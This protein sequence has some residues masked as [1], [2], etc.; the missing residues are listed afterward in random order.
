MRSRPRGSGRRSRRRRCGNTAAWGRDRCGRPRSAG[1]AGR[2][3][4][5]P[6]RPRCRS[7]SSAST[8]SS[9]RPSRR[10]ASA[11]GRWWLRSVL[12]MTRVSGPATASSRSATSSGAAAVT[13]GSTGN[14]GSSERCRNGT[15]TSSECSPACGPSAARTPGTDVARS[16]ARRIHRYGAQRR[17]PLR[18]ARHRGPGQRDEV[19]RPEQ[20]RPGRRPRPARGR[21]PSRPPVPSSGSRRAA[22]PAPATGR[23]PDGR[24]GRQQRVDVGGQPGRV[25]RVEPPGHRG[26]A[27]TR[28]ST[29]DGRHRRFSDTG[30]RRAPSCRTVH[31]R[32]RPPRRR[33]SRTGRRR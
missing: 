14:R 18:R 5:R 15:C 20:D 2:R 30:S 4:R 24:R 32:R 9:V 16:H 6:T 10:R 1:R 23:A 31:C 3:H 8:A 19:G 33:T 22:R 29:V 17:R 28:G 21:R 12:A 25:G 7:G 26:P 13:T 27:A 11:S